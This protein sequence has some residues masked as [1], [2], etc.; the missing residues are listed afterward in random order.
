MSNTV[1]DSILAFGVTDK[2][3]S[4][5]F[6]AALSDGRTVIHDTQS[7]KRHAWARLAEW[8]KNNPGISITGLRFQGP[9]GIEMKTPPNQKV[10]SL[11][12]S[13]MLFGVVHNIIILEL[14][15]MM[16]KKSM[17]FGTDSHYLIIH[18]P[19]KEQ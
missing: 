19:K 16:D 12:K 13:N 9:K 18:S 8:L 4:V 10:I 17:W 1:N 11:G 2:T 3:P 6:L 7:D 5:R 14:D 15:I